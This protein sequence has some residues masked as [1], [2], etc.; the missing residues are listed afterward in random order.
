MGIILG[1]MFIG[2]V[3]IFIR[4]LF[5]IYSLFQIGEL[6]TPG[7]ILGVSVPIVLLIGASIYW[8]IK[9]KVYA[10]NPHFFFL[11]YLIYF[12]MFLCLSMN[13]VF[14]YDPT[15]FVRSAF[16][17]WIILGSLMIVPLFVYLI[18]FLKKKGV[19]FHY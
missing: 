2:A 6:S 7:I 15:P 14:F 3:I 1:P 5:Q 19:K 11:F 16:L 8:I 10:F 12:P 18:N 9:V 17:A 13:N 4:A